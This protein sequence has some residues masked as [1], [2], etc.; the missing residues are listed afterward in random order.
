VEVLVRTDHQA[1]LT[2]DG[3]FEYELL[4]GDR[5]TV[6]A[7]PHVSRFVRMQDRHYFYRTLMERLRWPLPG[8][9][10]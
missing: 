9:S 7:S 10:D 1:I 6:E 8:C 2:V 4:D 5:V 3:Q